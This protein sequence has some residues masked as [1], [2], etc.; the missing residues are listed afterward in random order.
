MFL[1]DTILPMLAVIVTGY[2]SMIYTLL[3]FL[4]KG[5]ER[6]KIIDKYLD[7]V[8]HLNRDDALAFLEKIDNRYY[9]KTSSQKKLEDITAKSI[10]EN[11][12]LASEKEAIQCNFFRTLLIS[13]IVIFTIL[14]MTLQSVFFI[15]DITVLALANRTL[16]VLP[17]LV[18]IL[19]AAREASRHRKSFIINRQKF[20]DL[21]T[22]D[23]YIKGFSEKDKIA[24]KKDLCR[25]FFNHKEFDYKC[26]EELLSR[27]LVNVIEKI[28]A[29][30]NDA[31]EKILKTIN[32]TSSNKGA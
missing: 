19:F 4:R 22:I 13:T 14:I 6:K 5:R 8:K 20:L 1:N 17:F 18:L 31:M 32:Q 27:N 10:Y 9:S 29:N 2:I 26:R 25:H 12:R 3:I 15:N 21:N 24:V 7:S 30:S 16:I 11:Y 28:N 23:E